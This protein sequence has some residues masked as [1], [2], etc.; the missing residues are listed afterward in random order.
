MPAWTNRWTNSR[1]SETQLGSCMEKG[2]RYPRNLSF[3]KWSP[4]GIYL[5]ISPKQAL[6]SKWSL[7]KS[8][9][10]RARSFIQT[11]STSR[12]WISWLLVSP[13]HP[14]TSEYDIHCTLKNGVRWI[15][16]FTTF[17][18]FRAFNS[19]RCLNKV[20]FV[21]EEFLKRCSSDLTLIL[22]GRDNEDNHQKIKWNINRYYLSV[23][24]SIIIKHFKKHYR[25]LKS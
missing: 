1:C 4:F 9:S 25:P 3:E 11:G 12:L 2:L 7:Y 18:R 6:S 22:G 21:K 13:A 16:L 24:I 19:I 5:Y 10:W 15:H 17:E 20:F 14:A 8:R 23:E